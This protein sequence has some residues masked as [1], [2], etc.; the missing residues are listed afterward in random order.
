MLGV[1]GGSRDNRGRAF[2]AGL[3]GVCKLNR[4]GFFLGFGS[5]GLT[6]VGDAI[7]DSNGVCVCCRVSPIGD[8]FRARPFAL[9]GFRGDGE[10][11]GR[12]YP[13]GCS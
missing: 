12:S 5:G 4:L 7:D 9:R 13:K 8:S 10:V 3:A 1:G 6:K 11:I 2:G